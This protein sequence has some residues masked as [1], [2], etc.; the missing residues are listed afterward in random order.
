MAFADNVAH[1]AHFGGMVVGFVWMKWGDRLGRLLGRGAGRRTA[2]PFVLRPPD[3]EEAELDRILDKIHREGLDSLLAARAD[4]P[5]GG[6]A[7]A[8]RRWG[9]VTRRPGVPLAACQP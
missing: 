1:A 3:E 9:P 4:V 7:P 2:Q 6:L 5:P 8:P